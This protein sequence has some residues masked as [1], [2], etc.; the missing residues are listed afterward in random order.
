[1]RHISRVK[2][3]FFLSV[4]LWGLSACIAEDLSR[5]PIIDQDGLKEGYMKIEL[6]L[7][8]FYIPTDA[9]GNTK[10][11]DAKAEQAIDLADLHVLV[12]KNTGDLS[13]SPFQYRAP[14]VPNSLIMDGNKAT[15][16]IKIVK[17]KEAMNHSF[18]VY[19]NYDLDAG[20]Q[21]A[22]ITLKEGE[23]SG[24][25]VTTLSDMINL[26]FSMPG[27]KGTG[28]WKANTTDYTRFPMWG[29]I[30]QQLSGDI[31][32][33]AN[34]LLS[35]PLYRALARIDVGLNFNS[36]EGK[37]Q[38]SAQGLDNF[39][40]EEVYVYRTY[41]KGFIYRQGT[42]ESGQV[43][44]NP[45]VPGDAGRIENPLEYVLTDDEIAKNCYVREIYV[46]EARTQPDKTEHNTHCI[47]VGGT[48]KDGSGKETKSY[49]RLDFA[50]HDKTKEDPTMLHIIRNHRYIFNIKEIK[51][52]GA[53]SA[54]NAFKNGFN[55]SDE[56]FR[57]DLL[58][59]DESIHEMHVHGKY[60]FGLDSRDVVLR[61]KPSDLSEAKEEDG[62]YKKMVYQTNYPLT[63][64]DR[65]TFEWEVSEDPEAPVLSELFDVI[66]DERVD[67]KGEITIAAKQSNL[68]GNDIIG[69]LKVKANTFELKVNVT[70]QFIDFNYTLN[71]GTLRDHGT[72]KAG[73]ELGAE[74]YLTVDIIA[75]DRSAQGEEYE[76]W[77][78]KTNG[79][80]FRA[81]GKFDFSSIPSGSPLIV[82]VTLTL[83]PGA[84]MI[85]KDVLEPFTIIVKS[86]S[87]LNASCEIDITP[88]FT[89]NM[90]MAATATNPSINI[91][92]AKTG[93]NQVL[94]S[95]SNFGPNY[96]SLVKIA[97]FNYITFD[98]TEV[99]YNESKPNQ[100]IG[101][102]RPISGS[103]DAAEH[104]IR[105][106]GE[107]PG[108]ALGQIADIVYLSY[109]TCINEA[110]GL[111]YKEY[112]DKGGVIIAFIE[113]A[114]D[115]KNFMNGVLGTSMIVG[116]ASKIGIQGGVGWWG[117]TNG[118]ES[119]RGNIIPFPAN[120]EIV[121]G[122][123]KESALSAY[124]DD[125][126]M[127]GPFG[128][129]RELQWGQDNTTLGRV[130]TENINQLDGISIYSKT[131]CWRWN[132]W[133]AYA[134]RWDG[135]WNT[136]ADHGVTWDSNRGD[137][138]TAFKSETDSRNFVWF[139][140]SG[141]MSTGWTGVPPNIQVGEA[142]VSNNKET[143][144]HTEHWGRGLEP[145]AFDAYNYP[146][147]K[148][149][150]GGHDAYNS[151]VFCNIFAWALK[152][153]D[154]LRAKREGYIN[155]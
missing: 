71:C 111:M 6:N 67:G 118:D 62:N 13:T 48:F 135:K 140:D 55:P 116:S 109:N 89:Y 28:K 3:L 34:P 40:L 35:F 78:E 131:S 76:L 85:P 96:N 84:Q 97:D 94:T 124:D 74:H 144:G 29:A 136:K 98:N 153:S 102:F 2:T 10:S 88:V 79:I 122:A 108:Q 9:G 143:I 139:G 60:H 20:L 148:K 134:D 26:S 73:E 5:D 4:I 155:K 137:Y 107:A 105:G 115:I 16:T 30:D 145:F 61:G 150:T 24:D 127:N 100:K 52:A 68:T 126:V 119:P 31:D 54:D 64:T 103:G 106:T 142:Y 32:T 141:F 86:N 87:P 65:I 149:M 93:P 15:V 69:V 66:W 113:Y 121:S 110:D 44:T 57:Y 114:E 90:V 75:E 47:V 8:D 152:R 50:E 42:T 83:E 95:H 21:Q 91:N 117:T 120:S 33:E 151:T 12:F 37:F 38:E 46:P 39:K 147:P 146:I 77:V 18:R 58:V 36:E 128:D 104:W 63:L 22:D 1:M 11:M 7:P 49:Y 41:N 27:D 23:T 92:K 154:Q 130:P 80:S 129:V 112:L 51:F 133:K 132:N 70:Q 59:W 81:K 125:M 82:P 45:R 17:P 99:Q 72:Y 101:W 43:I 123:A 53:T 19:A 56:G 25:G 14:I 138:V